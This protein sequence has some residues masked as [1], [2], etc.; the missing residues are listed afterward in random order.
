MIIRASE[1]IIDNEEQLKGGRGTVKVLNFLDKKDSYGAGR[2]FGISTIKPGDSIGYHRHVGDFEVYYFLKGE[3]RV[4]DNG[5]ETIL[6]PGDSMMCREG[7][8]HGIE[9]I[10]AEDL[11][12]VSLILYPHNISAAENG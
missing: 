1:M 5:N 11:V 2:L 6:K 8:S 7:E 4:N 10:G 12:Y 9:N 3:A